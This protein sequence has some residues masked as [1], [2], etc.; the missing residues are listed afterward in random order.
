MLKVI[1]VRFELQGNNISLEESFSFVSA[2]HEQCTGQK[3]FFLETIIRARIDNILCY[4]NSGRH[5]RDVDNRNSMELFFRELFHTTR[6]ADFLDVTIIAT[7]IYL[8][9]MW[10]KSAASRFVVLGIVIIGSIYLFARFFQLYLS[11]VVLQAFFAILLI[12][13]VVIFQEELRRFFER[14]ST[15]GLARGQRYTSMEHPEIQA[16]TK[17]LTGLAQKKIGALV[18][19]RGNEPLDRHIESGVVLNGHI[20]EPLLASIFDP[21]SDGHDGA[22][23]IENGIVTKF[24]CHL[25]ASTN[26][27]MLQSMGMRHSA[28]LGIAERSDALC[29]VVSEENGTISLAHN[30]HIRTLPDVGELHKEL[31]RFYEEKFPQPEK[32]GWTKW[33][34]EN[35]PEKVIALLIAMGL[36]FVFVFQT[37][38][39]RR[40]F[41]VPLEYRNLGSNW[42]IEEQEPREALVT[43][44]GR[45]RAFDLL[46]PRTLRITLDMSTIKAG[47]QEAV[48]SDD[49]V[50]RPAGLS[51]IA[52]TPR[53]I[54]LTAHQIIT[55]ELPIKVQ[56][57]GTLAPGLELGS[58]EIS[59]E[60]IPLLILPE[61]KRRKLKI[62]TE[63]IDLGKI[64]QTTTLTPTLFL[65][66]GTRFADAKMPAVKVKI[67]LR[68]GEN[69]VEE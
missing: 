41:V 60:S 6:P 23:I 30:E 55:A 8:V 51:V 64:T 20:S 46:D 1:A 37:G 29:I 22:T 65:P 67:S 12:A 43:L 50:R 69:E 32:R 54:E 19:V 44:A 62:L 53:R 63:P 56:T 42:I 15:W 36:W 68:E 45:A 52:V 7:L 16:L 58:I 5:I 61:D 24:G 25:P 28:A 34:K 26:M 35:I 18:V 21:G 49:Y 39:L 2:R 66:A 4:Y 3:E 57:Y 13:L 38:N 31:E 9:L 17:S 40:D 33:V 14:V 10:F 59:P 47:T 27:Q 11:A 48:I